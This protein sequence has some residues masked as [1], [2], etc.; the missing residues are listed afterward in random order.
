[1]IYLDYAATT[2]VRQEA[3]DELLSFLTYD[4][5]FANSS[6]QHRFGYHAKNSIQIATKT[7][8]EILHCSPQ[9]IV[10]TSGATESNNLAMSSRNERLSKK[11]RE[12]AA[13]LYKTLLAAKEKFKTK[14]AQWVTEWVRKSFQ[15]NPSFALEYFVIADEATLLPCLKKNKNKKYRAFIAVFVNN[16]RLIDTI[17]LN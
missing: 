11:E 8:A 16:I 1:M 4:G 17:S 15:N 9:E 6:S 12:E 10:F 7:L 3:I 2:P 14:S 5:Q 13:I